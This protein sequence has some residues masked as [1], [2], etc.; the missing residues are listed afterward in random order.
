MRL[1]KTHIIVIAVVVAIVA[2]GGFMLLQRKPAKNNQGAS[3]TTTQKA[4]PSTSADTKSQTTQAK[5]APTTIRLIAVGDQLPHDSVNQQAKKADG[6]YDYMPFFSEVKKYFDSANIH[7]CNQEV[8][9]AG[10]SFGISGY[11]VFN[12]PTQFAKDINT[13]GCDVINRANNHAFD[14]GQAGINATLDVW[15]KLNKKAIAGS[16][17][18]QAEQDTI[19]YFTVNGVK[20]AFLAYAEYSNIRTNSSYAVN[21]YSPSFAAAQVAEARKNADVV[22]VSMHWGTEYSPSENSMQKNA[23]KLL[24][25]NGAD[26]VIGTGPHVLQPVTKLAKAGGGETL[27]W[28][29]LGN[30]LNTQLDIE[31]LIGGIAVM[32]FT[33]DNGKATLTKVGFMPTYMHYEWTPAQKAAQDLLTRKN[34]KI[35]PL[36]VAAE[37]MSRSQN[38]TS[39]QA[40]QDRVA[41]LLNTYIP[42]T[43]YTSK[44]Y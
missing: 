25:D 12:A 39:V 6:S 10:E 20:F 31:S 42:I 35:Y 41:K 36:D 16:N 19:H 43:M 21:I 14:K 3:I 18:N 38:N 8:T 9:S 1:R 15:D 22:L 23:A 24:A 11:P 44:T 26:V 7:F 29:S 2:V 17:R 28:Y 32:D 5:P 33:V 4:A 34:L 13:L 37:P 30:F 40:Q 27:V